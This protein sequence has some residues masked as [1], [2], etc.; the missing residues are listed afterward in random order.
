MLELIEVISKDDYMPFLRQ[1]HEMDKSGDG[2]LTR[3]DLV[4]LAAESKRKL[5]EQEQLRQAN[6]S[7]ADIAAER[8][9]SHALELVVPTFISVF[10]FLWNSTFGYLLCASG[11]LRGLAIGSILG[12]PPSRQTY[13]KVAVPLVLSAVVTLVTLGLILSFVFD[14]VWYM[15]G[16]P[17]MSEVFYGDLSNGYTTRRPDSLLSRI[18]GRLAD[19]P[20]DGLQ[21]FLFLL[22][23]LYFLYTAGVDVMSIFCLYM[24]NTGQAKQLPAAGPA[25]AKRDPAKKAAS[26]S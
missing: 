16:D 11:L 18:Q 12:L 1:F 10:G 6:L 19:K 25:P 7:Q 26:N 13:M 24:K 15:A 22:Y 8:L 2:R 21:V 20:V 23:C 17:L 14:P 3:D 4:Q 5:T 9:N